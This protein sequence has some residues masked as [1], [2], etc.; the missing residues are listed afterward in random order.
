MMLVS[1][2]TLYLSAIGNIC[3]VGRYA[4]ASVS[5]HALQS[6]IKVKD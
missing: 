2:F 6:K 1:P 5:M 3:T 4:G